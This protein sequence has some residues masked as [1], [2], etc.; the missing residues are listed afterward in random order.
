MEAWIKNQCN[1]R[2]HSFKL[3]F[4]SLFTG[5][6]VG[7]LETDPF[8]KE[9]D[10]RIR[11]VEDQNGAKIWR[12]LSLNSFRKRKQK[13]QEEKTKPILPAVLQTYDKQRKNLEWL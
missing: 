6:K 7:Q 11:S 4:K 5:R 9:V 1:Y 2:S 10:H 3:S 8:I 13:K 12:R